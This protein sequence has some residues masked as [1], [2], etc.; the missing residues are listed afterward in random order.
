MVRTRRRIPTLMLAGA[1]VVLTAAAVFF[2]IAGVSLRS[3]PAAQNSA[4]VDVGATAQATQQLGD[5]LK[6]AYSYDFARL[7][8]NEAAA[9]AGI[10]PGSTF[11]TQYEQLF[12]QV[13]Q[14]APQQ[15]AVVTATVSTSAVRE[16]TGDRAVVV[17]F[18]DQQITRVETGNQPR[19]DAAAAR[20]TVTGQLVDGAW[21]ISDLQVL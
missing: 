1:L 10:V 5:A 19:Q 14:L 16:I 13:R 3:T 6:A 9:K 7:D 12:G 11:M 20:L 15:K 18:L 4:L 2:G 17:I 8:Q 21:K